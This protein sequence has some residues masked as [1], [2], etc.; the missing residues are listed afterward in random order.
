MLKIRL[1]RIGKKN[2]PRYRVVISEHTK[3][4]TSKSLEILGEYNPATDPAT[5]TLKEERVKYWLSQGV[6]YS[7]TIRDILNEKGFIKKARI[8]YTSKHPKQ[9]K[10][11]KEQEAKDVEAK[12]KEAPKKDAD[13]AAKPTEKTD[14]KPTPEKTDAKPKPANDKPK[15]ETKK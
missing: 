14:P 2:S 7:D 13:A 8:N 10:K 5:I 11:V 1:A 12:A 6:Q 4:P 3:T 9:S 15:P